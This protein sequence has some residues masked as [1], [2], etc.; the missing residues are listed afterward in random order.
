M[1]SM[2]LAALALG[3]AVAVPAQ[4]L[5][6]RTVIEHPEGPI[7]AD[8]RGATRIELRQIG[9]AGA[10]GRS[11]SLRCDWTVSLSVE[12]NASA[13]TGLKATRSMTREG[14]LKGSAPGWCSSSERAAETAIAAKRDA[15]HDA[16]MAMVAQDRSVILVEAD[17]AR[18]KARE[19]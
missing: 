3:V 10:P 13:G 12:R 17:G 19:G 8:Y 2:T 4:A 5:E 9:N 14:V 11:G 1:K 6:H 15:L 7:A 18:A 16:M